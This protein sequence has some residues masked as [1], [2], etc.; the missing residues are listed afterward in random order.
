MASDEFAVKVKGVSKSYNG[1]VALAGIDLEVKR[2]E[3]FGVLGRNGAGKTTL[4]EIIEGLRKPD[5]GTISVLGMDPTRN[6]DAIKER[7]GAQLQGTAF[8]GKLKIIEI[9]KQFRN[10]YGQKADLEELLLK[11]ALSE[12]RNKYAENISGGQRQRLAL[13]QALVNDPDLLFLDEPT[14]GLD[15]SIRRQLWYTIDEMKGE[16]KT[17]LLTT[18]YIDEAERLCDRVC[19]IEAGQI[20]ALDTPSKLI[21]KVRGNSARIRLTTARP[22]AFEDLR[23]VRLVDSKVN[24]DAQYVL[25]TKSTGPAVV[26]LVNCIERQKNELLDLQIVRASL[27]DVYVELTGKGIK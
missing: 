12:V 25:E 5:K 14:A 6:L 24:G 21:A 18:H 13:A 20:I 16:G 2:G 22:L 15:T 7:I 9:L 27:E 1:F 23:T 11:V 19:I 4:I 10:Y 8:I 26:D 17:V 3:V